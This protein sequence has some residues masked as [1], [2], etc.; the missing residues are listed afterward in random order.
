MTVRRAPGRVRA[1]GMGAVGVTAVIMH[2][3]RLQPDDAVSDGDAKQQ[4]DRELDP[5]MRVKL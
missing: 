2:V 3:R 1:M 4:G 5:V